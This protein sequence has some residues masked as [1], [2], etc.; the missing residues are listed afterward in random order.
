MPTATADEVAC[1][2]CLTA[3]NPTGIGVLSHFLGPHCQPSFHT[4]CA[5]HMVVEHPNPPCPACC[6]PWQPSSDLLFHSQCQHHGVALPERLATIDTRPPPMALPPAP[7]HVLPLCCHRV[8]LANPAHPERDDA[9]T[10][11]PDRQM[12]WAPN[13]CRNIIPGNQNGSV[14]GATP[15]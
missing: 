5:A 7:R 8:I 15:P 13:Q 12:E 6:Q 1:P 11:L 4:G 2:I 9:W 14:Y 10:E 3:I